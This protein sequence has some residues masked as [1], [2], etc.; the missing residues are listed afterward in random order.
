MRFCDTCT[1]GDNP[2]RGF[3]RAVSA[4]DRILFMN[5]ALLLAWFDLKSA[6]LGA[7]LLGSVVGV[8]NAAHGLAPALTAALKQSAYTFFVAGFVMQFCR[9]LAGRYLSGIAAIINATL[10]PTALTV[11][12]VYNL[13]SFKGTPEPLWSTLPVVVLSL[14]SFSLVAR[15]VVVEK[16]AVVGEQ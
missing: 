13:H 14:V 15:A 1:K 3:A 6:I 12:F 16:N 7:L 5:T 2:G 10:V 9:W 4:R 8:I 11:F